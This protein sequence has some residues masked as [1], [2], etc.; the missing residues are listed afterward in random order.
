M[1]GP[2]ASALHTLSHLIITM[3]LRYGLGV[4]M[5]WSATCFGKHSIAGT[6][7]LLVSYIPPAAAF[8]PQQQSQSG[9]NKNPT[10]CIEE[11]SALLCSL[12]PYAQE[13]RYCAQH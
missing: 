1:E 7:A 13:P 4:S 12:Q 10:P 5:L 9:W 8:T 2:V 6:Q 11:I 3:V